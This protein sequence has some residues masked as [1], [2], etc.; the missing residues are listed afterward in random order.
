MR[1]AALRLVFCS[2]VFGVQVLGR[3]SLG[4]SIAGSMRGAYTYA[5]ETMDCSRGDF[6]ADE[7]SGTFWKL[8][9]ID[10]I[11]V[12]SRSSGPILKMADNRRCKVAWVFVL[13]LS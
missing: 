9:Q 1:R 12:I 10:K 11:C 6:H 8:L 7:T 5:G 2:I 4:E 3:R 13:Y